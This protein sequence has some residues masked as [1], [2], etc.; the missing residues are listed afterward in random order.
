[1]SKNVNKL[2]SDELKQVFKNNSI[3]LLTD[4]RLGEGANVSVMGYQ[5]FKLNRTL[6][7]RG[8]ERDLG[9]ITAYVRNEL[10]PTQRYFCKTVMIFCGLNAKVDYLT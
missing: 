2:Q 4:S 10:V 1:M 9:G 7:K 5:H 6:K 3:V 8:T